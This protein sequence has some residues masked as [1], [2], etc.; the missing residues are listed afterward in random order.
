[1]IQLHLVSY[2]WDLINVDQP[3]TEPGGPPQKVRI[4]NLMDPES[5]FSIFAP[6]DSANWKQLVEK[7][8]SKKKIEIHDSLPDIP[9]LRS[10]NA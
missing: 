3:P 9:N 8:E 4:I 7:G 5:G 2:G 10:P 1:M 6:F